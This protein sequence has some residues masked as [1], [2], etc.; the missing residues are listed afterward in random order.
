[1]KIELISQKSGIYGGLKRLYRLATYFIEEGHEATINIA[2]G[3]TNSW[4]KHSVPE[5][6]AIEPN[7]RIVPETYQKLHPTAKNILYVQAQFDPPEAKYD[8]IVTTTDFLKETLDGWGCKPDYIIP[9]GFN[10]KLFKPD[11]SKQ[12]KGRIGYMPRKNAAE[13][14]LIKSMSPKYDFHPIDGLNEAEVIKELQKCDIFMLVSRT[15]GFGMTFAEASLCGCLIIGYHGK[16]GRKWLTSDSC[17]LTEFPQEISMKLHVAL[18]EDFYEPRR[19]TL[20]TLIKTDLTM[21]KEKEA[22]LNVINDVSKNR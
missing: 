9:Y 2:D 21:E 18:H 20:Q 16:G 17:I 6:I 22:W 3:S 11:P 1:V 7:I 15:E 13:A 19:R 10:S 5:N 4:F 12:I 8:K 14:D